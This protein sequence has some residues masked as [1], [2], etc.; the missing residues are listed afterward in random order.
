MIRQELTFR[1]I[2]MNSS[3]SHPISKML[4]QFPRIIFSLN[5]TSSSCFLIPSLHSR[6]IL[7]LILSP[8]SL[9]VPSSSTSVG[10]SQFLSPMNLPHLRL[11]VVRST[12]LLPSPLLY[13]TPTLPHQTLPQPIG[14]GYNQRSSPASMV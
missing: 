6:S 2:Y 3:S 9:I 12:S 7:S 1:L 8:I 13:S 14:H 11:F 4:H 10:L 5:S